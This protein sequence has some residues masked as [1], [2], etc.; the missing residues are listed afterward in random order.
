MEGD[1]QWDSISTLNMYATE[2][3]Q[4]VG[5]VINDESCAGNGG[6]GYCNLYIDAS[7]SWTVTGDSRLTNLNNEGIIADADNRS[8]TII[9]ADG[10]VL[11]QGESAWKLCLQMHRIPAKPK[12]QAVSLSL[13]GQPHQPV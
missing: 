5:A 2:G 6:D 11:V 9:S 13:Q 8:V 7:S 3:S 1:V 12:G 10:T 4:L